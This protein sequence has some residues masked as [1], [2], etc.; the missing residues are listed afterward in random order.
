MNRYQDTYELILELKKE[1]AF[2]FQKLNLNRKFEILDR[3]NEIGTRADIIHLIPLAEHK[4]KRLREKTV[5]TIEVLFNKIKTKND[6]YN[7]LR[8][9]HILFKNLDTYQ[10][11]YKKKHLTPL[12]IIASMNK[13][14][15]VRERAI[16]GFNK[17]QNPKVIRYL[18]FRLGDWVE[19]VRKTAKTTL[20]DFLK[21]EYFEE[22]IEQLSTIEW[23]LKVNRVNL[24]VE[25][26]KVLDF[27]TI[28]NLDY[29]LQVFPKQKEKNRFLLARYILKEENIESQIIQVLL[30]DK[31]F[32]VRKLVA[33]NIEKLY[34]KDLKEALLKDKHNKVRLYTLYSLLKLNKL[35]SEEWKPFLLDKS[36]WIRDLARFELRTENIDFVLFYKEYIAQNEF[37][38][39]AI[40]GL[41]EVETTKEVEHLKEYLYH[42]NESVRQ[43]AAISIIK[44]DEYA[45]DDYLIQKLSSDDKPVKKIAINHLSLHP[46]NEMLDKIRAIYDE[47]KPITKISILQLLTDLLQVK[48]L[49]KSK[50]LPR[51]Y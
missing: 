21:L 40:L 22:F 33:K 42:K 9:C 51:S 23:L 49:F 46:D 8:Y 32:L 18:L 5:K 3:I 26:K 31:N 47:A 43:S 28:D 44:M 1:N 14:G 35:T 2:F 19:Q 12:L 27:L 48:N 17:H 13:N 7:S 6:I 15:F 38:N 41:G 4:N 37:L 24:E 36:F 45:I 30:K 20:D 29:L 50:K 39:I 34:T 25:Y 16:K 10:G 11:I